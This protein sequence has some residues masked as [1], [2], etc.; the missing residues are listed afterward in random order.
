MNMHVMMLGWFYDPENPHEVIAEMARRLDQNGIR[1]TT[2]NSWSDSHASADL[3][4]G[5]HPISDRSAFSDVRLFGQRTI[6][7]FERMDIAAKAGASVAH[8]CSPTDDSELTNISQSWRDGA[9]LKFDWSANRNGVF[10]WPLDERR[11]SFPVD[12]KTGTDVF[13]EFLPADPVTYKI[14]AFAGTILGAWVLPTNDMRDP[15]WQVIETGNIQPFDPPA[16]VL[17]EVCAASRDLMGAGVGHASFDLMRSSDNYVL[18]EINTSS[19]G[20]EP[21]DYWPE[22]YAANYSDAI[23]EALNHLDSIPTYSALRLRA[24]RAGN[25]RDVRGGI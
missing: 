9:V 3:I 20:T 24:E 22:Q 21:W 19:A 14:D 23:I 13:M 17:D 6:S 1:L 5:A 25:A 7:R 12:F 11:R 4:I 15:N 18:I 8:F 10:L 2:D 16:E